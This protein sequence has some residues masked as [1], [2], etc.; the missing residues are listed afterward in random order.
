ML[1]IIP[2]N[3]CDIGEVYPEFLKTD[4][5]EVLYSCRPENVQLL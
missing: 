3:F 4:M 2:M 1:F 5:D